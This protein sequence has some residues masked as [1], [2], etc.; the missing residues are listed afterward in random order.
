MQISD[1]G[2]NVQFSIQ[3]SQN[4]PEKVDLEFF[5]EKYGDLVNLLPTVADAIELAIFFLE[6]EDEELQSFIEKCNELNIKIDS[7]SK[8]SIEVMTLYA[9][10]ILQVI[11][12]NAK[13]NQNVASNN[14]LKIQRIIDAKRQSL[15][16]AQDEIPLLQRSEVTIQNNM[17]ITQDEIK[18]SKEKIN[19]KNSKRKKLE[20]ARAGTFFCAPCVIGFTVAIEKL[21]DETKKLQNEQ[22]GKNVKLAGLLIQFG[23]TKAKLIA[24]RL[25]I[26]RLE[27][28]LLEVNGLKNDLIEG[29]DNFRTVESSLEIIQKSANQTIK[30]LE[31]CQE[32]LGECDS[33][34]VIRTKIEALKNEGKTVW[35]FLID[36]IDQN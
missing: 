31:E 21:K 22:N 5:D 16:R 3:Q 24:F 6:P 29:R 20:K 19:D 4:E 15:I 17:E 9:L 7:S 2:A 10:E 33:V 12:N 36:P 28:E 34:I 25:T 32:N 35:N 23:R 1:D 11:M 13:R 8:D 14:L 30:L 26:K 27:K 18:E